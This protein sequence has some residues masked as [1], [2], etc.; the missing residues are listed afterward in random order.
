MGAHAP[1]CHALQAHCCPQARWPCSRWWGTHSMKSSRTSACSSRRSART[2]SRAVCCWQ[3]AV[4][5]EELTH[6]NCCKRPGC[7]HA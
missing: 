1:V 2:R 6:V 7:T 5:S 4:R 3:P